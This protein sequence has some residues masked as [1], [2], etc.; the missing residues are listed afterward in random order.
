MAAV[1]V[2]ARLT[3]FLTRQT[4]VKSA[5][6]TTESTA[7]ATATAAGPVTRRVFKTR[8]TL[9]IGVP[10]HIWCVASR[11]SDRL[12]YLLSF[13][14]GNTAPSLTVK[15]RG[16]TSF[17]A[18]KH[19]DGSLVPTEL[20]FDFMLSAV[21]VDLQGHPYLKFTRG[22]L[23][24]PARVNADGKTEIGEWAISVGLDRDEEGLLE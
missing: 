24:Y 18:H 2:Q 7:T 8:T 16:P 9:D 4:D 10:A 17:L 22:P 5:A 15:A 20:A 21:G 12:V 14:V 1:E 3:A 13:F 23:L 19:N 11:P 6:A